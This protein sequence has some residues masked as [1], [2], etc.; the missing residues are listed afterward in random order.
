MIKGAHKGGGHTGRAPPIRSRGPTEVGGP[1][2]A[3][4]GRLKWAAER[5]KAAER[6]LR[7]DL[8]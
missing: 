8:K 4:E 3:T 2:E 1:L 5:P 6:R 7:K